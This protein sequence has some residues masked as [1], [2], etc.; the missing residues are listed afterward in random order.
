MQAKKTHRARKG[1]SQNI[2]KRCEMWN[3]S[4]DACD[5]MTGN[6]EKDQRNERWISCLNILDAETQSTGF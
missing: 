1:T 6:G 4:K 5:D 2:E 3:G